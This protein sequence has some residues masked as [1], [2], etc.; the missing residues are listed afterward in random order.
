MDSLL[1]GTYV[2]ISELFVSVIL[3]GSV[4]L[5]LYQIFVTKSFKIDYLH[6][7]SKPLVGQFFNKR[8]SVNS[9]V[10]IDFCITLAWS[11]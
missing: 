4:V 9:G 5:I 2:T 10:S 8:I 7:A 11:L 3:F 1:V 6:M